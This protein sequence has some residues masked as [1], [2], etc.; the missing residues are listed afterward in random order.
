MRIGGRRFDVVRP[1][2]P[3]LAIYDIQVILELV[4]VR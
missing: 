4:L 1:I 3:F 2:H